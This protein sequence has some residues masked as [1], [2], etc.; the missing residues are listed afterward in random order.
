MNVMGVVR[1]LDKVTCWKEKRGMSDYKKDESL[2]NQGAVFVINNVFCAKAQK[3][4]IAVGYV[5]FG[6]I[7]IYDEVVIMR[8]GTVIT[9][10][11][12]VGIELAKKPVGLT[13]GVLVDVVSEGVEKEFEIGLMISRNLEKSYQ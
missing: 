6:K 2:L 8:N 10:T 7:H 11:M 9:H 1:H 5:E 3:S 13:Q 4:T 12:I